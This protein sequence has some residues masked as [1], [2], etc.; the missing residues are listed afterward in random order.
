MKIRV[1]R[2]IRVLYRQCPPV[3]TVGLGLLL[4]LNVLAQSNLRLSGQVY[5]RHS[6]LPLAG[7]N[8]E[9]AGTPYG[10]VSDADGFFQVEN[11]PPGSYTLRFSMI[12]YHDARQ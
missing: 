2:V 1:I 7:V 3:L 4:S 9:V 10:A 6:R 8:V 11:I 5:D 12:G